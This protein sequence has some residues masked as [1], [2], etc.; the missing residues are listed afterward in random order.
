MHPSVSEL[1]RRTL[2]PKLQDHPSVSHYPEVAGMRQRLYWLD[3]REKES[4]L[5]DSQLTQVSKSND[6]E[7]EMV[8]AL[9][10]H[11]IRQG[12][13]NNRG[14]AV[15]TPYLLQLRKI[16]KRLSSAFEIV[17][18]DRDLEDIAKQGIDETDEELLAMP[19]ARKATLLK[20][21][22]IATIGKLIERVDIDKYAY[23]ANNE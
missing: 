5:G 11:L 18:S 6:Y 23:K 15:I 14:I 16:R 8:A 13:Y 17:I 10:S 21:L 22:R 9:V 3:H 20:A 4:V 19:T 7:V 1:V 2:Y 12:T